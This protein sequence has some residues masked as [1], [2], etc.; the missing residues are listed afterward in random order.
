MTLFWQ[1]GMR[2][3]LQFAEGWGHATEDA[4]NH[5]EENAHPKKIKGDLEGECQVGKSLKI[6]GAGGQAVE[7]QNGEAAKQTANQRNQQGF[8]EKGEYDVPGVE[9]EC[10]HGGNFTAAFGDGGVHG[11]EGAKDRADG[12][13]QRDEP[14]KYGDE[15][16]HARRLLSVVVDFASYV[17]TQARIGGESVS[18]L[19]KGGRGSEVHGNGLRKSV[20]T[21]IGAIQEVGVAPNLGIEGASTGVKDAHHLP[22]YAAETNCASQSQA[23]I[24]RLGVFADDEFGQTRPKHAALDDFDI[25]ANGKNVWRDTA[26]LNDGIRAGG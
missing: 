10:A 4:H 20:G 12:H 6:H 2:L 18:Q 19:L 5:S 3:P 22:T 16:G 7:G 13:D 11:V 23:R 21:L 1:F 8:N 17:H 26:T 9:A 14:A 24:G 15:L 25:A